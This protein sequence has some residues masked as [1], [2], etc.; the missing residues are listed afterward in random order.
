MGV[1]KLDPFVAMK[2]LPRKDKTNLEEQTKTSAEETAD[3]LSGKPEIIEPKLDE[4][5]KE[6]AKQVRN[7]I[8]TFVL[9]SVDPSN[10][11]IA[12]EQLK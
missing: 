11:K 8:E 2:V 12:L 4:A 3:V 7:F 1:P 6:A 10:A 9:D 5:D